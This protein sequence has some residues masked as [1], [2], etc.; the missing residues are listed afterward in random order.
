M[1]YMPQ[2][3]HFLGGMFARSVKSLLNEASSVSAEYVILIQFKY[4]PPC[5]AVNDA[6][7]QL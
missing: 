2:E 3:P 7:C 5:L 4:P 1:Q 6:Y